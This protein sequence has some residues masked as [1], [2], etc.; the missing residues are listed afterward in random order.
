MDFMEQD[1]FAGKDVQTATEIMVL[2]VLSQNLME[3]E[4]EK[5]HKNFVVVINA[6]NVSDSGTK[7]AKMDLVLQVAIYAAPVVLMV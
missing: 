5:F 3:E 1:P 4:L 6:R 2:F 7:D